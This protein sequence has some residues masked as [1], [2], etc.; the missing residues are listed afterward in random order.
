MK[1]FDYRQLNRVYPWILQNNEEFI[2]LNESLSIQD[3]CHLIVDKCNTEH[4]SN[5]VI[6]VEKELI[7]GFGKIPFIEIGSLQTFS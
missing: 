3:R 2:I 1:L 6:P 5:K 7:I 4:Q